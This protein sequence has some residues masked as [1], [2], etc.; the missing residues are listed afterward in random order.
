[1]LEQFAQS[2]FKIEVDKIVQIERGG[3]LSAFVGFVGTD[4]AQKAVENFHKSEMNGRTIKVSLSDTGI[5][6]D[7]FNLLIR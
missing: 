6:I 4:S 7:D 3:L 5:K 1:M 2:R